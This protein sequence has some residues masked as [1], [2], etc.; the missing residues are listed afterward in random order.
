MNLPGRHAGVASAGHPASAGVELVSV[1]EM[2]QLL[3]Q[4]AQLAGSAGLPP[5]AFA[6]IAWQAYLRAF[7]ELAERLAEAQFAASLE[8][9]RQNGRLGKA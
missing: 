2:H 6:S 7:P 5:E 9:L 1:P 4:A 3:A 8:E